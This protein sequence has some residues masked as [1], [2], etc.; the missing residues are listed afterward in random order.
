MAYLT[1]QSTKLFYI[2]NININHSTLANIDIQLPSG[3]LDLMFCSMGNA[4]SDFSLLHTFGDELNIRCWAS[5]LSQ[6]AYFLSFSCLP[7][8]CTMFA[9][10]SPAF[11]SPDA[12]F[13]M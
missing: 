5:F 4:I 10:V 2:R 12:R 13:A 3:Y 6:L 1:I 11:V 7:K 8:P 9:T